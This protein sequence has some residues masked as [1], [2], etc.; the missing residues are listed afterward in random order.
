MRAMNTYIGAA[1]LVAA[2][3]AAGCRG[4]E[5]Q[6]SAAQDAAETRRVVN[7]EVVTVEPRAFTEYIAVTGVLEAERDVAVAAEESGV[8]REL[9]VDKG[10]RVQAGQA[11]ARIDDRV[12]RAPHDQ[13][14]SEAE[15]AQ[16]TYDRQRRLWEEERIGTEIS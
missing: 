10:A 12:L 16:E 7:V 4:G 15:L 8:I 1:V 11:I 2:A 9:Y 3:G 5:A 6:E 14:Q 13:A